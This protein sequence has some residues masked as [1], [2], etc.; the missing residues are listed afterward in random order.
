MVALE[1]MPLISD[2]LLKVRGKVQATKQA[3]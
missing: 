2:E 1:A 3:A